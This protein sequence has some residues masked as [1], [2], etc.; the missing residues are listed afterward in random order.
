MIYNYLFITKTNCGGKYKI[1]AEIFLIKILAEKMNLLSSHSLKIITG[2]V[3]EFVGINRVVGLVVQLV[4]MPP[5]HG[6]GRGFESRPVRKR[7]SL[8]CNMD[9]GFSVHTAF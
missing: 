1:T 5:C 2:S 6:G 9:A 4:R 8:K 7:I 3:T